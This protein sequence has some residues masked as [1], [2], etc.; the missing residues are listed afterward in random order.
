MTER[1][2]KALADLKARQES[3]EY[4]RCPRC[5][6]NSMRP[7]LYTNAL[8]RA[9]DL[10]VCSSCGVDEAKLAWMCAPM[11]LYRWAALQPNR[12]K[13]DFKDVTG[14]EAWLIIREQQAR[15]L[16]ALYR[17]FLSGE[18]PEEVRYLAFERIPGLTE[19]WTEP[20]QMK[21]RCRDGS[22]IVRFRNTDESS[23]EMEAD[24]VGGK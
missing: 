23:W 13:G 22:L 14:R 9:A 7:D 12:P 5:G 4:T 15:T 6:M 3:G 17:L 2:K 20:Y 18:E 11:S 19:I 16:F 1:M 8:S 21:Y 10:L 24:L